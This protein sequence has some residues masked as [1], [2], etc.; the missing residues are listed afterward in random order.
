MDS[1][2]CCSDYWNTCSYTNHISA[3]V[4]DLKLQ[5]VLVAIHLGIG[6]LLFSMI[7]L[8]TLFAFK[9]SKSNREQYMI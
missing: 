5:A 3:L 4:I 9:I 6:L 1:Q 2:T 8:T 7:S